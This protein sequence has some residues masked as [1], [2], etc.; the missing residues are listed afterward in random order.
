M[1]SGAHLGIRFHSASG[2][3]AETTPLGPVHQRAGPMIEDAITY[4]VDD[5]PAI[6]E[7][8]EM[9]LQ[10][11]KIQTRSY[12]SAAPFLKDYTPGAAE[13][14]IVDVRMPGI[15]GL[16]LQERLRR[17][18]YTLPVI[19]MTAHADVPMAVRAM[20]AG[21]VDFIEKPWNA[22]RLLERIHE[23]LQIAS[24]AN[25]RRL[26]EE[27][28]TA[29]MTLL[30]DREREVLKRVVAG[31]YNKVIAAEL[32]VSVSTV[33]AHRRNIMRKLRASSLY[34]LVRIA[35]THWDRR[36]R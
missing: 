20:K 21:A 16:D 34:E 9:L 32:R 3:R 22:S 5:N 15:S 7:S 27:T 30:S 12:P 6:R 17:L 23:A 4:I 35:D 18:G 2:P 19:V 10:P 28:L 8:I 13:C 36:R 11:W 1:A 14:L 24:E 26:R 33:E 25:E 29:R 31:R